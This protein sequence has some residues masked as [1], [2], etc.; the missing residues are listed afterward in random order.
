MPGEKSLDLPGYPGGFDITGNHVN[1][2]FQLD[3]F[4]EALLLFAAAAG[5]DRLDADGWRAAETAVAAIEKRWGDKEAGIWELDPKN[6]TESRLICVAGLRAMTAAGA[7]ANKSAQWLSLAEAILSETTATS[8]HPSGRWQRAPD[9]DGLDGALL[10]PPLRGAV[11]ADD[12]RTTATLRA[13]NNGLAEDYYMYRFRHQPGPLGDAEG[14]FLLCGF[15]MAMAEH[16]Q[17][18]QVEAV[19]WFERNRSACGPPGLF[20]EEYD[21]SQRQLRGNLPQ[22]FV[23]AMMFEASVRLATPARGH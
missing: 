22:A 20:S 3:S 19:R 23:H 18:N 13:L 15:A 2:Q 16:Q 9:D 1:A 4:G 14:A 5:H 8:V 6:W 10:L 11:A 12:P 7:P 17:G 21:V